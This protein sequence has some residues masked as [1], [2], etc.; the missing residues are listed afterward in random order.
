[1]GRGRDVDGFVIVTDEASARRRAGGE[2]TFFSAGS[3]PGA[4][5]AP[6]QT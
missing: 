5:K 2:I 6:A 3:F 1:L 4:A